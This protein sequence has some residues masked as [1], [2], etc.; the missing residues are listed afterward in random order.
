MVTLHGASWQ[1][2]LILVLP[3]VSQERPSGT[4]TMHFGKYP[5]VSRPLLESQACAQ[6]MVQSETAADAA[7]C[8]TWECRCAKVCHAGSCL[9]LLL[10]LLQSKLQEA[11]R[12]LSGGGADEPSYKQLKRQMAAAQ[13][14]LAVAVAKEEQLASQVSIMVVL[15]HPG[16]ASHTCC[17]IS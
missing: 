15:Y 10:L 3:L 16:T 11:T 4:V 6:S 14:Q 13:E 17:K 8:I 1:M 9:H 7:S 5:V 2:G 12:Q